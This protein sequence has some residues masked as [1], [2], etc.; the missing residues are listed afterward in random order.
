MK[1]LSIILFSIV[2]FGCSE[3]KVDNKQT[4]SDEK[5]KVN[6]SDLSY[7]HVDNVQSPIELQSSLAKEHIYKVDVNIKPELTALL[8]KSHT[9]ELKISEGSY[10]E[11]FYHNYEAKQLHFHTPAEHSVDE[12]I[13]PLEMHLVSVKI[14]TLEPDVPKYL[15]IGITFKE[16][17]SNP[18]IQSIIENTPAVGPNDF[19]TEEG[20]HSEHAN[21]SFSIYADLASHPIDLTTLFG[22]K[23]ENHINNMFHY[24]GSLTTYPYTESVE[25]YVLKEVVEVSKEQIDKMNEFMGDNSRMTQEKQH[26]DYGFNHMFD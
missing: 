8:R 10:V 11:A 24:K 18:F 14:D 2:L 15:V 26:L 7:R 6:V 1:T 25:W 12:L 17:K 5:G 23:F 21:H 4:T 9:I 13:H 16:G 19:K 3:E 20:E 22:D